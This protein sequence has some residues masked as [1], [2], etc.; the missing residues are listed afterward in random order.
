MSGRA[1]GVK[2]GGGGGV[3]AGPKGPCS[4]TGVLA[5]L[6]RITGMPLSRSGGGGKLVGGGLPG[7]P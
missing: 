1:G 7:P 3:V 6:G 2:G 4:V 5:G